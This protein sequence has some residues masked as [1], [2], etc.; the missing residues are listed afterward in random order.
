MVRVACP[1]IAGDEAADA[2][3][4]IA[5]A[6]VEYARCVDLFTGEAV[7]RE[8][9]AADMYGDAIRIVHLR[10]GNG[11]AGICQLARRTERVAQEV[12]GVRGPGLRNAPALPC[13]CRGTAVQV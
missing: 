8:G 2:R 3:V 9:A 6:Q 1:G 4:V 10:Q 11:A 7:G 13:A 12:L 5:R